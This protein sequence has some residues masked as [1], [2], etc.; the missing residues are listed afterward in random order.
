MKE[1]I[2][3]YAIVHAANLKGAKQYSEHFQQVL[4]HPPKFIAEISSITTIHAGKGAVAI[5]FIKANEFKS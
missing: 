1:G 2:A 5:A 4:G 3:E